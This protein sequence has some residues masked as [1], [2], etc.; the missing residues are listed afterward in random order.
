M[1]NNNNNQNILNTTIIII[2]IIV[3]K[4]RT[5]MI[6]KFSKNLAKTKRDTLLTSF[7]IRGFM[8]FEKKR[9]NYRLGR[10]GGWGGGG[11][12]VHLALFMSIILIQTI[13]AW[14][15]AMGKLHTTVSYLIVYLFSAANLVK[16]LQNGIL[17]CVLY[18]GVL[19]GMSLQGCPYWGVL[20]GF[21]LQGCPYR[22]V[23]TEVSFQGCLCRVF[24]QGCP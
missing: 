13:V 14:A 22:D 10:E 4:L 8:L 17:K 1:R 12:C 11:G 24:L 23:F 5:F 20:S 2:I 7:S 16:F 15:F 18:R 6:L 19:T 9:I 3:I 21:S